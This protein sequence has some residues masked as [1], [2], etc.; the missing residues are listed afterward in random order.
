MRDE[1]DVVEVPRSRLCARLEALGAAGRQAMNLALLAAYRRAIAHALAN[2]SRPDFLY[3]RGVPFW[4]FPL[5]RYFRMRDGIPYVLDFGD[6]LYMRGI[7]YA[8]GQRAGLRHLT[9][10]AGEAWSVGGA[11]LVVHTT[12]EQT[13]LYRRRYA[14]K[15]SRCFATIRWGYDADELR[16][17][18]PVRREGD[19]LRVV[20]FGKFAAYGREDA[21]ALARCV[22]EIG[23][24]REVQVV[25]LGLPEQA[26][27]AAF[28]REGVSDR[29]RAPGML[30]YRQGLEL[31]GSADC[32]VLNAI[33]RV[34]VPVKAYDYVGLNRPILAFVAPGSAAGRMLAPFSGAFV[35]RTADQAVEALKKAMHCGVLDPSASVDREEFS[36]QH[37]FDRL[38]GLL[39]RLGHG[40]STGSGGE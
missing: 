20:I 6:V 12:P 40:L 35:V 7:T 30:P 33:S 34:S 23:R 15:P 3:F 13:Q 11:D 9:D 10:W 39:D 4:Y 16:H 24:E 31:L 29:L 32:C 17:I 8:L 5:S 19:A 1:L 26:L 2:G 27:A 38:I 18:R 36:Q 28:A 25:Q 37:Q 14:W 21:C 22:A